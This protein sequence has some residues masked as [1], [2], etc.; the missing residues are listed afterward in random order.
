MCVPES[1]VR[2]YD[3]DLRH[4]LTHGHTKEIVKLGAADPEEWKDSPPDEIPADVYWAWLMKRDNS[5]VTAAERQHYQEC[6]EFREQ[7]AQMVRRVLAEFE[8]CEVCEDCDYFKHPQRKC[9]WCGVHYCT[10][11]AGNI[12]GNRCRTCGL[13]M[14]ERSPANTEH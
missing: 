10:D 13:D 6:A 2:R 5:K 3:A 14:T 1:W 11:C 12:E 9:P 7:I 4:E 8:G